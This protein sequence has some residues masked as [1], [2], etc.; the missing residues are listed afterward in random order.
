MKMADFDLWTRKLLMFEETDDI[1]PSLNGL[2]VGDMNADITKM[3]FAV[4]A[5][6]DSFHRALDEK[7]QAVFVHHGLFWGPALPLVGVLGE[8][9]RFLMKNDISLFAC[10]LPLDKHAELG[11]NARIAEALK[12]EEIEPFGDFKGRKIGVKGRLGSESDIESLIIRLFGDW[13]GRIDA[14]RFGPSSIHTIGVI[15]GGGT[16]EVSQAIDEGLDLYIT[17]DSSHNIYHEC[18]EAGINVIFAGHYLTEVF[19]VRAMA[20][21]V[22]KE[23]DIE[24]VFVDVPTGY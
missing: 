7:A 4:D 23:T 16:R 13:D 3:V 1:D 19:G 20:E 15:S 5:C 22:A 8:R 12:L 9:V 10:H 18:R 6:M 2:Q 24:T 21:A 11:N 17:G 14:L